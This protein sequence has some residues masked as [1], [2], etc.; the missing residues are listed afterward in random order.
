MSSGTSLSIEHKCAHQ[1]LGSEYVTSETSRL[2]NPPQNNFLSRAGKE[3]IDLNARNSNISRLLLQNNYILARVWEDFASGCTSDYPFLV[4]KSSN[5]E[6]DNINSASLGH[7]IGNVISMVDN[8]AKG[9]T[10]INPIDNTINNVKGDKDIGVAS[11][12]PN[13]DK[14]CDG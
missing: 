8:Y 2:I 4:R 6:E 10:P 11:R 12:I 7:G 5:T 13:P 3:P 14:G 9:K 1:S